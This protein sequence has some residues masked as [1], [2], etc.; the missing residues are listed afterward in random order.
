[1]CAQGRQLRGQNV[2]LSQSGE[3]Q[4]GGAEFLATAGHIH[5]GHH[6]KRGA[7]QTTSC[8]IRRHHRD[9]IQVFGVR[10]NKHTAQDITDDTKR[11][12]AAYVQFQQEVPPS[13][14]LLRQWLLEAFQSVLLLRPRN[15]STLGS[16]RSKLL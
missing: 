10:V 12:V 15:N 13:F 7:G 16:P 2:H 11:N 6:S 3:M 9:G 5:R 14:R 8:R 1:M 4:L